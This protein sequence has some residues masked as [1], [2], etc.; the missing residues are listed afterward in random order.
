MCNDEDCPCGRKHEEC[1]KFSLKKLVQK[2]QKKVL[3]L[4]PLI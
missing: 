2:M 4:G 1:V 3:D